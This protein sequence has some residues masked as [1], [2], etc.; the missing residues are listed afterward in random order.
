MDFFEFDPVLPVNP[1]LGIENKGN[2]KKVDSG[3]KLPTGKDNLGE[4]EALGEIEVLKLNNL[5]YYRE[6][7]DIS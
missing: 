7:I 5:K 4:G 3:I 1:G 2:D 6:K